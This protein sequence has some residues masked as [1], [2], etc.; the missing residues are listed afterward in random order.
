MAVTTLIFSRDR[1]M[2][3]DAL[4]RSLRRH[5]ADLADSHIAVIYHASHTGHA[6]QYRQLAAEHAGLPGLRFVPERRFQRDV[7][8]QLTRSPLAAGAGRLPKALAVARRLPRAYGLAWLRRRV[9][10]YV[11]FLVD[12]CLCVRDFCLADMTQRLGAQSAALGFSLRLGT[13][14]TTAYT[15]N[16]PQQLPAFERLAPGVLGFRWVGADADF[17]FPLEISSS[18]YRR[19]DV[20]PTLT[21]LPYHNPNLLED[22]LN[23]TARLFTGASPRLLCFEQSAAFCAPVNVVQQQSGE[24]SRSSQRYSS[25]VLARKFD[26]GWRIDAA[27]LSGFVPS[28]CHQDVAFEFVRAG[29]R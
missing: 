21:V 9:G 20:L 17:G 23:L 15:K 22:R 16:R 25:D 2:Q 14:T 3:L 28:A 7:L 19:A 6:R 4:L 11:L 13:N 5:C 18:V 8:A 24:R 29:T 26:D 12:D 10:G 1:A 27:Q